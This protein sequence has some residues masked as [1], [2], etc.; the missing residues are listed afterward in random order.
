MFE[1]PLILGLLA[2]LLAVAYAVLLIKQIGKLPQGNEKMQSI[3][4]AIREGASAY[5]KRQYRTVA[6]VAVVVAAI[7]AAA[8][9]SAKTRSSSTA[10]RWRLRF[11]AAQAEA[12]ALFPA[13]T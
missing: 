7:A 4:R 13:T 11:S 9:L 1:A 2:G 10:A 8:A 6:I 3:A 5:M 12:R